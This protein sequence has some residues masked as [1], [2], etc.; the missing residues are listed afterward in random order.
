MNGAVFSSLRNPNYRIFFI[1]SAI[2]SIGT[3]DHR[4][5]Q[6]WLVLELTNSGRA[7]GLVVSAQFLPGFFLAFREE[8]LQIGSIRGRR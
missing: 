3:W 6:D 5:A 8:P 7:L 2:S 1:G 4:I